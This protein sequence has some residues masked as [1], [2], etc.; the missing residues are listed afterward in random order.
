MKALKLTREEALDETDRLAEVV[1]S[2]PWLMAVLPKPDGN[3]KYDYYPEA[4]PPGG[5]G[6]LM[7]KCPT[8]WPEL[9]RICGRVCPPNGTD[10]SP[11]CDC[12]AT[13]EGENLERLLRDWPGDAEHWRRL[14]YRRI[15]WRDFRDGPDDET[16]PDEYGPLLADEQEASKGQSAD[17]R[18]G[19]RKVLL[20][21]DPPR[22]RPGINAPGCNLEILP[23][24][25]ESLEAEI[26]YY[27]TQEAANR[28]PWRKEARPWAQNVKP[29]AQRVNPWRAGRHLA[30][31]KKPRERTQ[32][33]IRAQ[34]ER[35]WT[36]LHDWPTPNRVVGNLYPR[37]ELADPYLRAISEF[38]AMRPLDSGE[39][40]RCCPAVWLGWGLC[41]DAGPRQCPIRCRGDWKDKCGNKRTTIDDIAQRA[42]ELQGRQ[43]MPDHPEMLVQ[44]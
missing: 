27:E 32:E 8:E 28:E 10:G 1:C 22:K 11:C 34:V 4:Y 21:L 33:S 2:E 29:E 23:E 24:D 13:W 30:E 35:L 44:D 20:S 41:V 3:G 9:G 17:W 40:E 42:A 31:A 15:S 6:S 37:P 43:L 16:A 19:L 39:Y 7:R 38:T 12:Q 36:P 5:G 25:S 14:S 18:R 26:A